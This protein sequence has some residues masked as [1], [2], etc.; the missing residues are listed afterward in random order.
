MVR[1]AKVGDGEWVPSLDV[2]GER[3]VSHLLLQHF[4]SSL[5]LSYVPRCVCLVS[6]QPHSGFGFARRFDGLVRASVLWNQA[7]KDFVSVSESPR[8]ARLVCR[9]REN[10]CRQVGRSTKRIIS[11]LLVSQAL[12][13]RNSVKL[14]KLGRSVQ[15]MDRDAQ[16]G[17]K[18]ELQKSYK[19][20]IE[21]KPDTS[22]PIQFCELSPS[23]ELMILGNRDGVRAYSLELFADRISVAR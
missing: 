10:L 9:G 23:G 2:R 7:G 1:F 5:L 20:L 21:I 6:V 12:R 19:A 22:L 11:S 4:Y 18:M 8:V 15:K 13:F 3:I 16:L 17:T 14:F